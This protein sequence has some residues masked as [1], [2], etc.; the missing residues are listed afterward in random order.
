M[1]EK[2]WFECLAFVIGGAVAIFVLRNKITQEKGIG[3]RTIQALVVCLIGPIILA[4]GL[5]KVLEGQT[6]AALV[7]ALVGYGIPKAAD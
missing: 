1:S 3:A 2:F 4:L 5:E 6:I 7:G